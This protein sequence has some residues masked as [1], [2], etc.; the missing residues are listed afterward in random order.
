M[1]LDFHTLIVCLGLGC[2]YLGNKIQDEMANKNIP[3]RIKENRCKTQCEVKCTVLEV[4][5]KKRTSLKWVRLL[6]DSKA[7]SICLIMY[8]ATFLMLLPLPFFAWP[9][10]MHIA[11][12]DAIVEVYVA[13]LHSA[14][15]TSTSTRYRPHI[16]GDEMR[17]KGTHSRRLRRIAV[18][19]RKSN[20]LST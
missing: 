2:L 14:D 19:C 6:F 20:E 15:E 11:I 18:R 12:F 10:T 16:D 8:F 1:A 5:W 7:C 13:F 17:K 3:L 4:I 9:V